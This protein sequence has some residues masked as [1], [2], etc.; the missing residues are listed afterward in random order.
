M[1]VKFNYS[2]AADFINQNELKGLEP[3]VNAAREI[4]ENKSGLGNDFLGWV[5]LPFDYD[6]DEFE[7]IK[8]AAIEAAFRL[9]I[10]G[11]V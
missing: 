6:K 7:R 1:S 11:L 4:L 8:K 3:Q 5:N 10:V 2:Y 9:S